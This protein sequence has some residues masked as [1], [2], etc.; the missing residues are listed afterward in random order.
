MKRT[1]YVALATLISG[2]L[3]MAES[4][5]WAEKLHKIKTGI[6]PYGVE[7]RLK[8]ERAAREQAHQQKA[9]LEALAKA[10]T[11]GDGLVSKQERDDASN[12]ADNSKK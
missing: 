1:M 10:D 6:W 8:K 12:S 9:V 2:S 3:L 11:N 4:P 7:E 5:T